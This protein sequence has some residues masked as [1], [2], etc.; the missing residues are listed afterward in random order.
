MDQ[1]LD[2]ERLRARLGTTWDPVAVVEETG[3]TNA[4]LAAA[5]RAGTATAGAV[6]VTELQV[7]GRGRQG[8]GWHAPPGRALTFST[9]V[10]PG[11]PAA[12]WGW[13]PLLA[14]V[15][16]VDAVRAVAD[17]PVRLK[18]PNDLLAP[19]GRKLAGILVERVDAALAVVGIGINVRQSSVELPVESA[20]SLALVTGQ[21]VDRAELLVAVLGELATRLETWRASGDLGAALRSAYVE[22]SATLGTPVRVHLPGDELL[23]GTAVEVDVEGRLVVRPSEGGAE[24]AVAAGDVVHV[25]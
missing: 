18:W 1:D 3:S 10:E 19:D 21:P 8:R 7:A 20:T 9:L 6:L 12:R 13:L 16:L 5:A 2:V 15:A 24:R 17:V 22:R 14:G 23:D 4:D 11:V 25:R